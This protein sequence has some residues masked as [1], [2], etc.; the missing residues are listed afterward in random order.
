M[1]TRGKVYTKAI[2][3]PFCGRWFSGS[4]T[5]DD[6]PAKLGENKNYK[7][8]SYNQRRKKKGFFKRKD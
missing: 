6:C 4:H 1:A 3:C 7:P 8:R 2:R 5:K